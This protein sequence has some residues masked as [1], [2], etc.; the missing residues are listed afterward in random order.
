MKAKDGDYWI[1]DR[2]AGF[3]M[4]RAARLSTVASP[5]AVVKGRKLTVTGL[6]TRASWEDL[7]HHGVAGQAVQLQ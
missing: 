7:K 6:L 4:K 2:V 1:S 3:K 5:E